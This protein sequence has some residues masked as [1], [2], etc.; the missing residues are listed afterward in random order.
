[1]NEIITSLHN[2]QIKEII[3]L[4]KTSHRKKADLILVEGGEEIA[5]AG[6]AAFKIRQLFFCPEF[7]GR[8]LNRGADENIQTTPEVFRKIS[9][10]ENPD[11]MLALIEP[12]YKNLAEVKLSQNPLLVIVES[13]EKPGNLGAILRTADACG[14]DAVII[15]E[16]QTD[17]YNPNVIRASIGAVFTNQVVIAEQAMTRDWLEQKK[18]VT[19]AT[20]PSAKTKYTDAAL[21]RPAAILIGSEPVGLSGFWL[22][23]AQEKILIPMLGRINSLNASVSAAIVLYE[24]QRQRGFTVDK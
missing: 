11:G 16:P 4:R 8:A 5:M 20:T 19:Y 7:N 13:V 12:R 23:A 6:K 24:A 15:N 14:A 22:E 18:I 3:R 1:M 21:N 2:T 9:L 10:R 17:I